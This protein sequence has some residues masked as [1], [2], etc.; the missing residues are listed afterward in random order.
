M[1]D[2]IKRKDFVA[3]TPLDDSV[4]LGPKLRQTL[5][6]HFRDLSPFVDYLCASLDLEF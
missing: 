3:G 5:A 6:E 2:D 1:I 4:I